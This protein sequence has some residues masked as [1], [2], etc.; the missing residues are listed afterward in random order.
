M[1]ALAIV[2]L[3]FS[4][5]VDC[6]HDTFGFSHSNTSHS[7]R[8][9]RNGGA[10][11]LHAKEKEA[12][13]AIRAHL[14][15]IAKQFAE[16]DFSAPMFVHGHA[17][18]GAETMKTLR[19]KIEYRFEETSDGARVR[20]TTSDAEALKAVHAFLKFQ[21]AEHKTGDSGNVE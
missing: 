13:P 18:D 21:I 12:I 20:I 1:N 10:I 14:T 9:Y 15:A 4:T 2:L 7:F 11:E 17:P 8:L 16:G 3:L 19:E 5:Q 6:R